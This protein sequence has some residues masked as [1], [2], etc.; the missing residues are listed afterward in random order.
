[1]SANRLK[2]SQSGFTLIEVTLAIVIGVVVIAGATVLYNQAKNSAA[3]SAAQ[4][5]V[6]AAASTVEEFAAK[7]FGVYPSA[8]QFA[9]IWRRARVDDIA[10]SP[11]G[12]VAGTPAAG[13]ATYSA[14]VSAYD[15][16]AAIADTAT[17][18]TTD[19][20]NLVGVIEY[21]KAATNAPVDIFDMQRESETSVRNY[22]IWIYNGQ[23]RGP[24]FVVGGK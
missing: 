16:L 4:S 23:G 10:S 15:T 8:T 24:N 7:N 13:P 17:T 9:S 14:G 2:H 1:M 19:N 21:R 20:D 5:K 18:V 3:S 12:G 11:W 22:G 6:N